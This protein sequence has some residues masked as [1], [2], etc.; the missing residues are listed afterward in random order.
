MREM[1]V[2]NSQL[3]KADHPCPDRSHRPPGEKSAVCSKLSET[4]AESTLRVG[5]RKIDATLLAQGDVPNRMET[6]SP[7][8]LF[9]DQWAQLCD[10]LLLAAHSMISMDHPEDGS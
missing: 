7:G 2:K 5:G 1:S 8:R 6:C 3:L 10:V 9:P 4:V